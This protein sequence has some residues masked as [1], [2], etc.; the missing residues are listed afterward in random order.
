MTGDQKSAH[1]SRDGDV[2]QGHYSLVE[3]DGAVRTVTYTAD[4][5]NGFNAVVDRSPSGIATVA[6]APVTTIA[7]APVVSAVQT[8]PVV[9]AVSQPITL[10]SALKRRRRRRPREIVE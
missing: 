8:V 7:A 4:S 3:P 1:E 5:I 6:A 2:V 9:S 10:V